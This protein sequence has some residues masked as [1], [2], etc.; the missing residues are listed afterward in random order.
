VTSYRILRGEV[1]TQAD[2]I[3]RVA[4]GKAAL[5]SL[6]LESRSPDPLAPLMAAPEAVATSPGVTQFEPIGL[7]KPLTVLI[8]DV[9]TGALPQTLFGGGKPMALVTGLKDYAIYAAASRAVNFLQ[10]DVHPRQ[11]IKTPT[12]FEAGTN[13]VA[14]SPAVLADSLHYTV[15]IAFDRFPEALV[16][17]I[18]GALSTLAGIPLLMPAQGYLLAAS[19]LISTGATWADALI[20]GRASFSVTDSLDFNV[21]GAAQPTADFR[22]LCHFDASGM[23]YDPAKGLLNRDSSVYAGDAPYVVVSFDGAARPSLQGF[24]PTVASAAIMKQF[25]AM[26]DGAQASVQ[27]LVDAVKVASDLKY[28]NDAI[29]LKG[30][31][32]AETDPAK[33][34]ALQQRLDA[35]LANI[36]NADL[37]KL[38]T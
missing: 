15:E 21:P 22:V 6:A 32:S 36:G 1:L 26:R 35:T 2:F 14:Y 10:D 38:P 33:K 20:D 4:P 25:F 23:T 12:T 9:Y 30:Q 34:A 18:S 8:R 11:R 28:R 29:D 31:V 37:K 7:G 5:E 17:A 24:A 3:S 13:V 16:S 19:T 27:A